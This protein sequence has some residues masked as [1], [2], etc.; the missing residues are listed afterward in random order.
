MAKSAALPEREIRLL[1]GDFVTIR[2]WSVRLGNL[3][4][5]RIVALVDRVLE[6]RTTLA[7]KAKAEG[8]AAPAPRSVGLA[9]NLLAVAFD[10]VFAIIRDTIG[11][12]SEELEALTYEDFLSLTEAVIEVCLVR[13]EGGVLGKLVSLV[14]RTG[15]L[16]GQWATATTERR[17]TSSSRPSTSSSA[18]ATD[19]KTSSPGARR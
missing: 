2:P 18:R 14:D 8:A 10:D 17:A 13:E 12:T 16:I 6:Y 19:A 3:M 1:S 4:A 11:Y 5:E 9:V 15:L 7:E